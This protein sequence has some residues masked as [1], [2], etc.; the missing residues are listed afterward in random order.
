MPE[1]ADMPAAATG[2]SAACPR[3]AV[4]IPCYNEAVTI[5]KV[6]DDFRRVLPDAAIW[7]YDNNSTDD[8]ARIAREHGALVRFEPRQGK[9]VTVRQMLRDIDADCY[10]LVDG[11]DTYPA[12]AAPA[13]IEPV[14]AGEADMTVGDR[15]SNGSYAH[16]NDRAF[17]GFGNDLVRWLIREVPI[18]YRDRPAGSTSKLSTVS[19]GLRVL[20]A[21]GALFKD[22]H[23]FKFFSLAALVF[24]VL[25]IAV[26]V[27]VVA[28]FAATGFV[29]KL[30]SA[31]LATGLVFCGALSFC[32]G[33]ILDTVAKNRRKQWELE[34]YRIEDESRHDR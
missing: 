13:L 11:D 24:I 20:M 14:L 19:D 31:V 26:G 25:G 17:H 33:C 10:L 16:E 28:E 30:P 4:L 2:S 18:T 15:L 12:E 9:G 6:V 34:V 29:S 7:V 22:C 21:I 27:P 5:G 3:V 1:R 8:T 32:T 23:P